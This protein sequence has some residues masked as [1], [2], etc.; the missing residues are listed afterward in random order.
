MR[1]RAIQSFVYQCWCR[2][3]EIGRFVLDP[4]W[5][6]PFNETFPDGAGEL[7]P[8]G[9]W[10]HF[11]DERNP[12]I[13]TRPSDEELR[14]SLKREGGPREEDV[15]LAAERG[16]PEAFDALCE[17]LYNAEIEDNAYDVNKILVTL[18][19]LDQ[20][21]AKLVI[22]MVAE[23]DTPDGAIPLLED[24]ALLKTLAGSPEKSGR[25]LAL[26][27]LVELK[28]D[29]TRALMSLA[30]HEWMLLSLEEPDLCED[31]GVAADGLCHL[32]AREELPRLASLMDRA[33]ADGRVDLVQTIAHGLTLLGGP[34]ALDALKRLASNGDADIRGAG[35]AARI[36]LGDATVA[37]E[38]ADDLLW[39][40][41]WHR[42]QCAA[43]VDVDLPLQDHF[44]A[45]ARLG[46]AG[47][48]EL[49]E[50]FKMPREDVH[51]RVL[52]ALARVRHPD[53]WKL[54][55]DAL[56]KSGDAD[57][58]HT[59]AEGLAL[60]GDL[61]AIPILVAALDDHSSYVV[62]AAGSA[63]QALLGKDF[64]VPGPPYD[65]E[66]DRDLKLDQVKQAVR[67]AVGSQ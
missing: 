40:G 44:D 4:G 23:G 61:R 16:F 34:E 36:L 55:M 10:K 67:E 52:L 66:Y 9:V 50:M 15:F 35:L 7:M 17:I 47:T 8:P 57:H 20:A 5:T 53:S 13:G 2:N 22:R 60:L 38:E 12:S 1:V 31:L 18:R 6:S 29:G 32:G 63:L 46:P 33:A 21:S 14:E 62:G 51:P 39:G 49:L 27:R 58:R 41:R 56:S 64:G 37:R 25:A 30:M 42:L 43:G 59:A 28:A 45:L 11:E 19:E 65:P 24:I 54:L 3:A 48:F 26:L